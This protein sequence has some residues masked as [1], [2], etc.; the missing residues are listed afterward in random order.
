VSLKDY[1]YSINAYYERLRELE[2]SAARIEQT[3][4][5]RIALAA[6]F[7]RIYMAYRG[8]AAERAYAGYSF[9]Q[10]NEEV[11]QVEADTVACQSKLHDGE[12]FIL[13]YLSQLDIKEH[14]TSFLREYKERVLA[15][16]PAKIR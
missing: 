12:P 16:I 2:D 11:E 3:I 1:I 9:E 4:T 6:P 8:R 7:H 10:I 13:G 5:E 14:I 15:T